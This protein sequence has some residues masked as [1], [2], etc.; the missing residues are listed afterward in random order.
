MFDPCPFV[1]APIGGFRAR[2][3]GFD[4]AADNNSSWSRPTGGFS[5]TRLSR[6][7]RVG[8]DAAS[9]SL[10]GCFDVLASNVAAATR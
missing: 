2:D 9:P 5:G 1:R 8:Y 3:L 4:V 6:I 7:R 10:E